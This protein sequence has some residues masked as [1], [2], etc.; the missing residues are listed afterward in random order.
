MRHLAEAAGI[1]ERV[2]LHPLRARLQSLVAAGQA[3]Q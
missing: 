1:A 3:E 2:G